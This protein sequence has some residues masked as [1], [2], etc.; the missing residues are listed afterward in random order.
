MDAKHIF[1]DL[2][3][4]LIKSDPGICRSFQAAL[5]H[6]GIREEEENLKKFIGP[7]LHESFQNHYHFA[8]A[9]YEKALKIFRAYYIEKGVYECDLYPGI[10]A[11][12]SELSKEGKRIYLATSKPEPQAIRI[13]EYFKLSGYFTFIGGA[14][15]DR[16][17]SR[18]TK[19]AVIAHVMK[20]TGLEQREEILMVGDRSH[21]IRG[22][23]ANKISSAGVLYG[24]GQR[25]ELEE[26]GADMICETVSAL[27]ACI[28]G[29]KNGRS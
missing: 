25:S 15:G 18:A 10:E 19:A 23:K 5:S 6:F 3:G 26:A 29:K 11:L 16:D 28:L 17:T 9:M 20:E 8:D 2:D 24:Y 21:D 4:T 12:L 14:D 22:A 7:P 1:F 13:L 27:R